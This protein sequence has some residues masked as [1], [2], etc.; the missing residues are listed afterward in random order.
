VTG[1]LDAAL[2]A[3][4]AGGAVLVEGRGRAPEI[5]E[6]EGSRTSI[7]TWADLRSQD[8]I[9]RVLLS[10][11]PDHAV[12]GEEGS[13][14]DPGAAHVW[15]VDPVDGTTNFY[16]VFPC[17]CLCLAL[18]DADGIALGVVFDP[19]HG[20][21]FA[22]T[23]DG[24]ATHNGEPMR[25]S[26]TDDLRQSLLSTQVQSDDAEE[27]GRFA[28]RARR[29]AAAGRAVR[30]IGS[31]ALALAYVARG[32]LDA[33]CEPR[34]SP[35]DTHPGALLVERAGGRVTTFDGAARPLDR[36]AS[37]AAS[38]AALHGELLALLEPEAAVAAAYDWP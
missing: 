17:Y 6:K 11:H 12:V 36:R 15:Y 32:W 31:P 25:V 29:F 27:V 2:E 30:T 21:L 16:R 18:R 1:F 34:M 24:P 38:N 13:A 9:T 35:W 8:E 26:A 14:G 33:F 7:V 22:A 23:R 10:R 20:D 4:R 19:L 5:E 3:A 37:I 28:E